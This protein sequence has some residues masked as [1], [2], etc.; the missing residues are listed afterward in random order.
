M[1]ESLMSSS[2]PAR[3]ESRF[4]S[5]AEAARLLGI[6]RDTCYRMLKRGSFPTPHFQVDKLWRILAE[7]LDEYVEGRHS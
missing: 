5:V 7:P 2:A 1:G 6:N 3:H 4:Y